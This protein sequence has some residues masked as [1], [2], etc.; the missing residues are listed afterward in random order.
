M[1]TIQEILAE[2][3]SLQNA[4]SGFAS[5]QLLA[6]MERAKALGKKELL[7]EFKNSCVEINKVNVRGAKPKF[8]L[9]SGFIERE[10][11]KL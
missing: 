7:Q 1:E 9:S 10:M 6:A 5:D 8:Y 3:P 4:Q 11:N 2:Y